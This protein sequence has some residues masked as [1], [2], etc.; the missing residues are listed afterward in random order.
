MPSIAI[1]DYEMGN[2]HSIAKA[3]EHVAEDTRVLVTSDPEQILSAG[4]LGPAFLAADE[5]R[6]ADVVAGVLAAMAKHRGPS[7]F[8]LPAASWCITARRPD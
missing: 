1:I 5:A 3:V 8:E 2:L 7:G 4:P 6:R